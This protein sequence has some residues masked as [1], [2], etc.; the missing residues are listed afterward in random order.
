MHVN[1][2]PFLVT[3]G[4]NLGFTTIEALTGVDTNTLLQGFTNVKAV[5]GY[6]G[7]RIVLAHLDNAF[8]HLE[9]ELL[10]TGIKP[11]LVAVNEHASTSN[12]E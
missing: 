4:V 2:I 7:F 11:N 9:V 8:R 5:Y 12:V 10:Q 3:I 6:R 1:K